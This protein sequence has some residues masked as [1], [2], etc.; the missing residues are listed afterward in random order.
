MNIEKKKIDLL[1]LV[2][3]I[4]NS[5][6]PSFISSINSPP[7]GLVLFKLLCLALWW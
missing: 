6:P 2:L 7:P 4:S 3:G 1:T 5:Q